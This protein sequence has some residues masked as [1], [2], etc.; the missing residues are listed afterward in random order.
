MGKGYIP[1]TSA[2]VRVPTPDGASSVFMRFWDLLGLDLASEHN[3]HWR[4]FVAWGLKPARRGWVK[5]VFADDYPK[6]AATL[7]RRFGHLAAARAEL[8]GA[9]PKAYAQEVAAVVEDVLRM[10]LH[11]QARTEE[12][13]FDASTPDPARWLGA[14]EDRSPIDLPK[15]ENVRRA[16]DTESADLGVG[17]VVE[18]APER[19]LGIAD[20]ATALSA[21]HEVLLA[22]VPSARPVDALRAWADRHRGWLWTHIAF[23]P[24]GQGLL[25]RMDAHGTSGF[26]M[27][28][29]RGPSN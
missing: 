19:N 16:D 25:V 14:M 18:F 7:V 17:V 6:H 1:N 10:A 20:L 13:R 9:K 29:E 22:A 28:L 27:A 4:S 26:T 11:L 15:A 21:A 24:G 3:A 8:P 23:A 12:A 2:E 5:V